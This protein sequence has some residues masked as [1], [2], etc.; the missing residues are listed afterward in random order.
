MQFVFYRSTCIQNAIVLAGTPALGGS[1][2]RSC[3]L[4]P[5]LR[6]SKGERSALH[7]ELFFRWPLHLP[8]S[9]YYFL[10]D[11]LKLMSILI[12]PIL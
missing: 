8:F 7:T 10:K 12:S 11:I 2:R 6:G 5:L 4:S 3:S 9:F 1:R